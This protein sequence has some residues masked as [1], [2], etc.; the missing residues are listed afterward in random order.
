[1]EKRK[2]HFSDW[3]LPSQTSFNKREKKGLRRS[4]KGTEP[5]LPRTAALGS[6]CGG[7]GC[8][9]H[10]PRPH[11]A[12][13]SGWDGV[14]FPPGQQ[15]GEVLLAPNALQPQQ[16]G[17]R[18]SKPGALELR[19]PVRSGCRVSRTGIRFDFQQKAVPSLPFVM[20]CIIP[21][22]FFS[23][24]YSFSGTKQR[25]CVSL[26][27]GSRARCS[28]WNP[29]WDD[30]IPLQQRSAQ[31]AALWVSTL[32]PYCR[33]KDVVPLPREVSLPTPAPSRLSHSSHRGL[34]SSGIPQPHPRAP[35]MGP[36]VIR[37]QLCPWASNYS[38]CS[39]LCHIAFS[40][41]TTLMGSFIPPHP[42]FLF[43]CAHSC[44]LLYVF[45]DCAQEP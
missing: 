23:P 37:E 27:V 29:G 40:S 32:G 20:P 1:M 33:R 42:L 25:C 6:G 13:P 9:S 16:N 41:G 28:C 24:H 34:Q 26:P 36:H 35:G 19:K 17:G 45:N 10:G 11:S 30:S 39:E 38:Q 4:F 5:P 14:R 21:S 31:T 8:I 12:E 22:F 44:V 2:D 43:S 15:D 3:Q 18:S 7:W